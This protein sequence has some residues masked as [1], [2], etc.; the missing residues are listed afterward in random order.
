MSSKKQ[1]KVFGHGGLFSRKKGGERTQRDAPSTSQ[2]MDK[3]RDTEDML[4]KKQEFLEKKVEAEMAVARKNAKTN[5]QAAM[6]ALKRKQRYQKQLQQLDGTLTTLEQQRSTLSD[7]HTNTAVINTMGHAAKALKK[8]HGDMDVD[9][10]HDMMDDIAE[11]QQVAKEI[12]DAIANPV[13]FG[14]DYDEDD[15]EAEL[16]DL[17]SELEADEQKQLER[18]LLNVGPAIPAT[19]NLPEVPSAVPGAASARARPNKQ[20]QD[21]ME[22]LAAWAS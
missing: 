1:H 8:A 11:Q 14:Y 18:E 9:Q 3:L 4:Q 2:A 16:N 10:V 20:E 17:E 19:A 13:A 7:A 5:K 15:L 22:A 21:D 6:A 12:S